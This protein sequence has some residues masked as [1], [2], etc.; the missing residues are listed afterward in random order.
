MRTPGLAKTQ[1]VGDAGPAALLRLLVVAAAVGRGACGPCPVVCI[2]ATDLVS[3]TN[4]N[5]SQ[6]PG[7]LAGLIRRL[8]LSYNSIGPLDPEWTPVRFQRLDTLIIRHNSITSI[9][10]GSFSAT[11]NLKCLDLSSN[12]L[13]AVRS[14]VFQELKVLEALLLYNNRISYL[15]PAAFGGLAQ[16]RKLYLSGNFLTQFPMD[17]YVGRFKLP[18][19]TF[20]DVSYNR[21]PSLPVQHIKSVP[22]KQLRGVYLH[23]NPFVCDCALL[24]LLSLWH[25][26]RFSPVVD[27]Q[28]DY[29]C[30]PRPRAGRPRQVQ[31][32]RGGSL[33][34]SDAALRGPPRAPGAIREARVGER[35]VVPCGSAT[36]DAGADF[37]WVG[38][39]DQALGPGGEVDRVRVLRD[40]SLLIESPRPEDA[41]V[42][43]CT[44]VDRRHLLNATADVTIQVSNRTAGRPHAHEAF[45]TALTTLA[46]CAASVALV[47]AYLYLTPCP[48]GGRGRGGGP[49]AAQHAS[50]PCPS[51]RGPDPARA[52]PHA[53][54]AKR[55]AFLEPLKG[56]AGRDGGAGLLPREAAAAE[57][58]L[59]PARKC[60][61][62]SVSSA[63]SDTP[64]V[65]PP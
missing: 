1:R 52:A 64:F 7:N 8:D 13:Q 61:S 20:L 46:A 34:C 9:S 17:L 39:D 53:A 44:A 22:G 27:F 40:G 32:L 5:L 21:I 24:S 30:R 55:V 26:R 18:E 10:T 41:G 12:K 65:A 31:L 36:G 57:G 42:Y 54:A 56:A 62:D 35:L 4:R 28:D 3:C 33:N 58:I 25:R 19:L 29:T 11:P 37:L 50:E 59:K 48:C 15:D 60:D 47:L 49:Q 45:S 38:P 43:S 14:A 63:F 2:C 23:G 6:V 51:A 16:L